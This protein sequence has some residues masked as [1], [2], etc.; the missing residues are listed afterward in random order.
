MHIMVA[1]IIHSD[2][3]DARGRMALWACIT[4]KV[5]DNQASAP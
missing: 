5:S 4:S 1:G 3:Q 2:E